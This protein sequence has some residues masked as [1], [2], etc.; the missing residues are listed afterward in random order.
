MNQGLVQNS[1][2]RLSSDNKQIRSLSSVWNWAYV[3]LSEVSR[4]KFY[5]LSQLVGL[6]TVTFG[7]LKTIWGDD[8]ELIVGELV[9]FG[10][11]RYAGKNRF[12][13]RYYGINEFL[14]R[15]ASRFSRA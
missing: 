11:I 14:Y 9:D 10:M 13:E 6:P 1:L 8:T 12:D 3:Q 4:Q 5:M 7:Q 2:P 15:F